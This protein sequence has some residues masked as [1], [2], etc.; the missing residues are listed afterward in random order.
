M[1]LC[2]CGEY[3]LRTLYTFMIWGSSPHMRGIRRADP[4]FWWWKRF[5]PAHAGGYF[6]KPI[7]KCVN[8]GSPPP[9]R[10]ILSSMLHAHRGSPPLTWGI[11]GVG[12]LHGLGRKFTPT[13]AGNT[14][15]SLH[16]PYPCKVHPLPCGEYTT[17]WSDGLSCLG[18]PPPMRGIPRQLHT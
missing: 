15:R 12:D 18:S 13:H 6:G 14:Y 9:M 8:T 4:V 17:G 5:I 3:G 10:G 11:Q 16:P 1:L 2:L 7:D